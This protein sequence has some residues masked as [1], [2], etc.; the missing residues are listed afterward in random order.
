M[1]ES[2]LCVAC[3]GGTYRPP[4]ALSWRIFSFFIHTVFITLKS[5]FG[6]NEFLEFNMY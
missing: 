3:L 6:L 2:L 1:N 5:K 4:L